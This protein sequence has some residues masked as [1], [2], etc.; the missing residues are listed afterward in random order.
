[1]QY[2]PLHVPSECSWDDA[3]LLSIGHHSVLAFPT[4]V[5]ISLSPF[6]S[7]VHQFL[8]IPRVDVCFLRLPHST[9]QYAG[10]VGNVKFFLSNEWLSDHNARGNAPGCQRKRGSKSSRAGAPGTRC[11]HCFLNDIVVDMLK[12]KQG[13]KTTGP[14]FPEK[15]ISKKEDEEDK[16]AQPRASKTF[17]RIADELFNKGVDDR[18]L[19]VT[20]HTLRHSFGTHVYEN[21]GDL[22]LT[23]KA[24]GHKTMVMASRYAN[25]SEA[26]LRE[27]FTMMSDVMKKGKETKQEQ[28]DQV[29]NS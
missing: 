17:Q 24:L 1:M 13:D 15:R 10:A 23:Q 19:R 12:L 25:M 3:C 21:S 6:C 22:Y 14:I 28:T 5:I 2:G 9:H 20:F 27:A 8:H 4:V 18:R 26:R 11:R 16:P 7:R 29:V